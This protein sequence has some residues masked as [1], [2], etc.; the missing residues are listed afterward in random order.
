MKIFFYKFLD[1]VTKDFFILMKE[2]HVP[3]IKR[4]SVLTFL[5][6]FCI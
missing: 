2:N 1:V 4:L 6:K 5:L 3:M